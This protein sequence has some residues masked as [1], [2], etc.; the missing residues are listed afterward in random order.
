[1]FKKLEKKNKAN[2]I[3]IDPYLNKTAKLADLHI[4][5]RPGTD[6]ALACSIMHN[7]LKY[8]KEDKEYLDK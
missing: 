1:M 4:K 6:G 2:F 5:I 3:V 7:I 8:G